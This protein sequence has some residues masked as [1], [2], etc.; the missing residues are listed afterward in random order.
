[1][2]WLE[3]EG[4]T[5]IVTGAGGGIGR[6]CARALGAAGCRVACLD[7][8]EPE[9]ETAALRIREAGGTASPESGGETAV[10]GAT[11]GKGAAARHLAPYA[12]EL[13]RRGILEATTTVVKSAC[14][15]CFVV[16]TNCSQCTASFP[17]RRLR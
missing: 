12:L 7:R 17:Q 13:A 16:F 8:A 11:S 9:A 15:K 4:R 5:A 6:A 14:A 2:S 10:Q 1:M 3:L